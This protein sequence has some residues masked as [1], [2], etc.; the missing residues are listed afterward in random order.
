MP[1]AVPRVTSG[2]IGTVQ[3]TTVTGGFGLAS[4]KQA[5]K[6][7]RSDPLNIFKYTLVP[8]EFFLFVSNLLHVDSHSAPAFLRPPHVFVHRTEG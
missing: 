8:L 5:Q 1:G 3:S 7:S 4:G 6:D 2:A